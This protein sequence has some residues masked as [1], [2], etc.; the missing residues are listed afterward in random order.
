VSIDWK[1][2]KSHAPLEPGSPE[3]VRR[4]GA[5]SEEIA[6]FILADRSP[7]LVGGPA[8]VGKSTELAKAAELLQ[9]HRVACLIQL[10]RFENMRRLTAD[11]MLLRITQ[12]LGYL[13]REQRR[14]PLSS[15]LSDELD[16]VTA[17]LVGEPSATLGV[18]PNTLVRATLAEVMRASSQGRITL[19][20]DGLEK[21]P[22]GPGGLELF[23]ALASL[24]EEAELVV[25]IPWHAAF[26]PHAD[27]VLG[28]GER[29]VPLR[30]VEIEGEQGVSGRDFL[31]RI[32]FQ[33]LGWSEGALDEAK[34]N[35]VD[36]AIRWSG[37][38][39]RTFL[40]LMADAGSYARMRTEHAWPRPQDLAD[41]VADQEDS[42]LRLL[43][44][45]D[46]AAIRANVGTDGRE[47]ELSRRIRLMAH[48]FLLERI[49]DSR[50]LLELHPLAR[51]AMEEGS[52]A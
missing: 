46:S 8:G 12:R 3:Y 16:I 37:G 27:T 25:V 18:A 7:L 20:F 11:R 30:A 40:Q 2:L 39:P 48:G 50:P 28:A 19:L 15:S 51:R 43:L 14:L 44:P 17:E 1:V 5:A 9:P 47:L 52:H 24:R 32:L 31:R 10:D 22:P 45:G 13:A 38:M 23:D 34:R 36:E 42:F 29:F 33:R 21:V 6:S 49:R 41:A 35:L 26:G 4:E